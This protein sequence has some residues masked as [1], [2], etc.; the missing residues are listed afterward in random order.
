MLRLC[1]RQCDCMCSMSPVQRS[2]C[3]Q[4]LPLMLCPGKAPTTPVCRKVPA[5]GVASGDTGS[6][7]GWSGL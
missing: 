6:E 3:A 5:G 2:G 1:R 7:G 4:A